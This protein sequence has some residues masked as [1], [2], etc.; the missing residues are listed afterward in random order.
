MHLVEGKGRDPEP[1]SKERVEG[2]WQIGANDL[3]RNAIKAI[4]TPKAR[5]P[6]RAGR[7]GPVGPS[8]M[9][10]FKKRAPYSLAA[11]F[12]AAR[13]PHTMAPPKP[14]PEAP[15]ERRLRGKDGTLNEITTIEHDVPLSEQLAPKRSAAPRRR[16]GPIMG[17]A[18]QRRA[19]RYPHPAA[20]LCEQGVCDFRTRILGYLN[21]PCA[22]GPRSSSTR[23]SLCMYARCSSF[24]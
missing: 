10:R 5:P 14:Q 12:W 15:T 21:Y 2:R 24:M 17:C 6:H 3:A 16:P 18:V 8:G 20:T 1:K 11:M 7:P 23:L 4:H 22:P 19:N 13:R 9:S